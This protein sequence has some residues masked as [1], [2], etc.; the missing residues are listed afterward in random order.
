MANFTAEKCFIWKTL[1]ETCLVMV[2]VIKLAQLR[3]RKMYC[4]DVIMVQGE[5]ERTIF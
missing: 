1:I 5:S 2:G 3:D 4:N